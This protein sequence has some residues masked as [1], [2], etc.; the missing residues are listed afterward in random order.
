MSHLGQERLVSSF[1]Y[2][3]LPKKADFNTGGEPSSTSL[4]SL[5][6][7]LSLQATGAS[8]LWPPPLYQHKQLHFAFSQDLRSH[9]MITQPDASLCHGHLRRNEIILGGF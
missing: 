9:W 1:V 3:P 8:P 7:V 4:W 6:Y 2:W 5:F